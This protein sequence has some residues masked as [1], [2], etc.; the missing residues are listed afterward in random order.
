MAL[1]TA[2]IQPGQ[3][4]RIDPEFPV[5]AANDLQLS[6]EKEMI[7]GRKSLT[8]GVANEFVVV[9]GIGIKAG[10]LFVRLFDR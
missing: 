6:L 2:Y 3:L 9:A 5:E 1:S 7:T 10:W 8:D 4:S